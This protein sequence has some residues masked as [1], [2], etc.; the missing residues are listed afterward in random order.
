MNTLHEA[1]EEIFGEPDTLIQLK[2]EDQT[3]IFD[4]A[5]A[6]PIPD[7]DIPDS[8][9]T[10]LGL[11]TISDRKELSIEFFM[12]IKNKIAKKKVS[13]IGILYHALYKVLESE[14]EII[15][16]SI[17]KISTPF[18]NMNAVLIS[19]KEY[20]SVEFLNED[21]ETGRLIRVTP[22]FEQEANELEPFIPELREKVLVKSN[23]PYTNPARKSAEIPHDAF[24]IIWK[25]ILTWYKEHKVKDVPLLEQALK[26]GTKENVADALEEKL[27]F[28]L[29]ADF[30]VSYNIVHEKAVLD[31]FTLL[32]EA[33]IITWVNSMNNLNKEG[34]FEKGL[35]KIRKDDRLQQQWWHEKW[36]PIARNNSDGDILFLDMA[37]A[38][39]GVVGQVAIHYVQEGP[40]AT[41][42]TS[43]FDYL[44]AF[45]RTLKRNE[46]TVSE[47]GELYHH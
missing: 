30:K 2:S 16:G 22:L 17:Y 13:E 19:D 3:I 28:K 10:S 4:L 39:E 31:K 15:A 6:Y 32:D 40:V 5:V 34:K 14:K 35:D 41:K 18:D 9:V 27:G 42:H 37:P 25:G 21:D 36:V 12:E 47:S 46:F 33:Q 7:E 8:S 1:Y 43:F 29:P 38:P 11:S 24:I 20:T 45:S 23:V 26:S 44:T